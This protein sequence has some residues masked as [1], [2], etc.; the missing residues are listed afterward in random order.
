MKWI[1]GRTCSWKATWFLP[2]L[3]TTVALVYLP[4]LGGGYT[5]DD[6]PNIV[7]NTALHVHLHDG[8]AAWLA[9]AF[10]SPASDLH[11]PLAML[12]F[13]FNHALTGL[14][15]WWMKVTNLCI[16]LLN[17]LLVFALSRR[18]LRAAD[19][20]ATTQGRLDATA[21][22]IAA[23]W[24]LNPI[25]LTAV[26]F[27]VQRM[28]SL[29]HTFVFAGLY[30]YLAARERLRTG[31][32]G[33]GVVIAG[34]A[35]ATVLGMLAKE[36]AALLPLYALGVEWAL[37]RFRTADA[38]SQRR[39][40]AA[41]AL[42]VG[43]PALVGVTFVVPRVTAP[44]AYAGR[45]FTLAER[46]L[47]EGR[48][49]LDY[50]QWTLLPR[51][52]EFSLYHDDYGP[53]RSLL[54][55]ATTLPSLVLLASLAAFAGWLRTRRPLMALGIAWFLL[56]QLLTAT[57]IP[58]ELVF[59]HRNYF[60]SLG[61][62]IVLADGLLRWPA[63][64]LPRRLGA[65]TACALL[66]LYASL[67]AIRSYEWRDP[68]H[69][70]DTEAARHPLSPRATYGVARELILRTG[71]RADSPFLPAAQDA[72]GRAMAVPNATALPATAAILLDARL[73]R[74]IDP[75][76]WQRLQERLRARPIG[77]EE[78][79]AM[80][81]LVDCQISHHCDLPRTAMVASFEASLAHGRDAEVLNVYGNYALNVLL[82]P[83]TAL[84]LWLE[85]TRIAPNVPE[86][87]ATVARMLIASG[88][89]V[90]AE[91][92]I[93]RVRKLGT[94]GQNDA[95][96]SELDRLLPAPDRSTSA[97]QPLEAAPAAGE[98]QRIR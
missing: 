84:Q 4:G 42:L 82:D 96:A 91:P 83:N 90:E 87:Q 32:A 97:V 50:L 34:L 15:P 13:A 11:R 2:L 98:A 56:A 93:R 92:Y 49:V 38:R 62:C 31:R 71:Y 3:L 24:A 53:S 46:L 12:S 7:D 5:F 33:L 55:P 65:T 45:D 47:T 51:L 41:F 69:F 72:L 19:D 43:L 74:S 79:R 73:H 59:E 23:A 48:V 21:L 10:S 58:L 85:A 17:T 44:E 57:V 77:P 16:H 70:A 64:G 66:M 1:V 88:R 29:S 68:W 28:E 61:L 67:T 78:R 30:A 89:P 63:E 8:W 76:L 22:W 95:M 27:I 52:P 37:L 54:T 20:C 14:D 35:L 94:F 9:A 18:L 86:Y 75:M 36:S 39:L 25:N 6:M 81:S 26:L 40:A 60:A 80:A